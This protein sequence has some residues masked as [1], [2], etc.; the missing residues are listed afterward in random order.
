MERQRCCGRIHM[1]I[2][3]GLLPPKTLYT[4][5][6]YRSS[7]QQQC[8]SH[9]LCQCLS[10][11]FSI[12]LYLSLTLSLSFFFFCSLSSAGYLII[13]QFLPLAAYCCGELGPPDY[14]VLLKS[15]K[16]C[17]CVCAR[18]R[19]CVCDSAFDFKKGTGLYSKSLGDNC[20][21]VCC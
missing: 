19:A 21:A 8:G 20:F 2:S 3:Q 17:V 16:V 18:A 11:S 13:R 10:P 12:L 4:I 9:S 15:L 6:I 14:R 1:F 5:P 7:E